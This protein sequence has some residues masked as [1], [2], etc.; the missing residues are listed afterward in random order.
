MKGI[1]SMSIIGTGNVAFHLG[2]SFIERGIPIVSV[3]GRNLSKSKEL[4]NLW[5]CNVAES[6]TE[7][8]T[9]FVLVC[10]TDSSV[11][12]VISQLP[13]GCKVAFTSGSIDLGSFSERKN[14]GVLYPL[15]TFS[16][17]KSINIFEV[18]MLIE[19]D[20]SDF[21]HEL[22]DLAWVVSRNVHF[23]SSVERKKYHLAAVWANNFTNH[24]IY[25]AKNYLDSESLNWQLLMPLL[26]E[27][28]DKLNYLNPYDAQTGPARRNDLQTIDSQ[29]KMQEGMQKELYSL[30]TKS[31][32]ETY[33]KHD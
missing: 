16:K 10:V 27:T 17:E 6:I 19:A 7:I 11:E 31:I 33:T 4:A 13:L 5:R 3:H 24:L 23:A 25:S 30:L 8:E 9:D 1:K 14:T 21:A 29:E 18:P 26:K 15:Q 28:V 20:S 2:N 32:Q 12:E 22:F